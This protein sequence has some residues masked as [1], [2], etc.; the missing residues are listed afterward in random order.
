VVGPNPGRAFALQLGMAFRVVSR[1]TRPAL[2]HA[3][4]EAPYAARN[5]AVFDSQDALRLSL[6]GL[7]LSVMGRAWQVE[8]FSVAEI[9]SR[10]YVQVALHGPVDHLVTL[11]LKPA[12]RPALIIPAL[13]A[14]IGHPGPAGHIVDVA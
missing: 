6:D 2:G 14:W 4:T 3:D 12:S 13:I 1:R 11:R 8:V 5:P 10:Q 7:E 9:S